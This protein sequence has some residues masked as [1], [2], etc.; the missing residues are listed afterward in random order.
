MEQINEKIVFIENERLKNF[1]I[2]ITNHFMSLDENLIS[3]FKNNFFGVKF[4]NFK[5]LYYIAKKENVYIF[6]FMD[7]RWNIDECTDLRSIWHEIKLFNL[8]EYKNRDDYIMKEFTNYEEHSKD[9]IIVSSL[10]DALNRLKEYIKDKKVNYSEINLFS[11]RV[12]NSFQGLGYSN[13]LELA[14]GD[15]N[16][17]YN[18]DGIGKETIS[19]IIKNIDTF[20]A[21]ESSLLKIKGI[22]L[23]GEIAEVDESVLERN[24]HAIV[25]VYSSMLKATLDGDRQ[26]LLLASQYLNGSSIRKLSYHNEFD[27]AAFKKF[28]RSLK[29]FYNYSISEV[30]DEM[31]SLGDS[32][33]MTILTIK[34][35]NRV[36][37]ELF[38]EGILTT[39]LNFNIDLNVLNRAKTANISRPYDTKVKNVIEKMTG[40]VDGDLFN[41]LKLKR[42]YMVKKKGHFIQ[43]VF[44]NERLK[45]LATL[46]PTRYE[47]FINIKGFSSKTFFMGGNEMV[48]IIKKF[49]DGE[50]D[51]SFM[52][53]EDEN[54]EDK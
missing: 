42:E 26:F 30:L 18:C 35:R 46:Q 37:Y 3:L 40:D 13:Y 50:V 43:Y 4:S 15:A 36:F 39:I 29:N 41:I 20:I 23:D 33:I 21:C 17:I 49:I 31:V 44:T 11:P 47:E 1:I 10:Q 52:D 48:E 38:I 24:Y 45:S 14:S 8:D 7:K 6:K 54:N 19:V 34:A 51:L 16:A 27:K 2:Y 12:I 25:G 22:L 9:N 28:I 5:Y 32:L 53:D